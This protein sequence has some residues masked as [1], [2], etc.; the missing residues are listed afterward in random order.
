[1]ARRLMV[2]MAVLFVFPFHAF[3]QQG[4]AGAGNLR[5]YVGLINQTYHPGIVAWYEKQRVE[6]QK[7]GETEVVRKIDI[8]LSGGFGSGFV[9]SDAQGNQYVITNNHV[10]TQSYTIS[11][12]FEQQDGTKKKYD[13]RLIAS[14]EDMDLAILDFPNGEK[15]VSRGL[16]LL[17]RPVQEGED[18]FTAGFPA[19]GITPVWQFGRGMVSNAFARFPKS[20]VDE[21]LMGPF[22]QHTAQ[23]D[24]GSS[25]GPLLVPQ[26]GAPS[27]YAVAGINTLGAIWRQS[28]NY[29]IPVSTTQTFIDNALNPKPDTFR[30]ALNTRLE[31]FTEGLKVNRALYPHISEYLSTAVVGENAEYAL[32]EMVD[33]GDI[34]ARRNLREMI[35][36]NPASGMSIAVAW[37]IENS[38]RSGTGALRA[39]IKEVTGEGEEYTV[40]FTINN[41]DVSSVWV[42]E[43]GNWR[44]RSFGKV[45][46][47]DQD[48]LAR[49]QARG[50]AEEKLHI[51]N[52]IHLEAGFATLFD[53]APAAIYFAVDFPSVGN[54]LFGLKAYIVDADLL[55]IGGYIGFRIPIPAG[56]FG[57]MPYFK[58][59]FDYQHD[60]EFEDFKKVD[61]FG[62]GIPISVMAQA[63]L[64]VTTSYVPGLFIGAGFQYN[65]INMNSI[66][67]FE[68]RN[69]YKNPIK[70]GLSFTAGYAF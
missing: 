61:S 45:A 49:R 60:K 36:S 67:F 13:L 68:D 9:Y 43:Y 66:G 32:K 19:L 30:S 17:N 53:K 27:G 29:S 38:I 64:K 24:A 47:G 52:T 40:V 1:M 44:I 41:K 55:S 22:I 12:S 65:I 7:Q 35:N 42:R 54:S 18:V 28:A 10:I 21:T 48:A 26:T 14:D 8:L 58:F 37:T 56:T 46:I 25:G 31:K 20:V 16:V 2:F 51:G 11:I 50:D 33:K 59:G 70:M 15:P 34:A 6:Y 3:S 62:A 57:F 63:G 69:Y 39:S 5:E 23:M 4:A